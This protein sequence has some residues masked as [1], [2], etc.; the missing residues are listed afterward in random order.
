MTP[1][2]EVAG[3]THAAFLAKGK[4]LTHVRPY[5]H[6]AS[7]KNLSVEKVLAN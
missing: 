5:K 7:H 6:K 3:L 1:A 4:S 2:L